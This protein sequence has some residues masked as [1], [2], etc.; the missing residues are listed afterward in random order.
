MGKRASSNVS[1]ATNSLQIVTF[2][3]WLSLPLSSP[4]YQ[5]LILKLSNFRYHFEAGNYGKILVEERTL[6]V[7]ADAEQQSRAHYEPKTTTNVQWT[8]G[9]RVHNWKQQ[10]AKVKIHLVGCP[11]SEK[12][13]QAITIFQNT[14]TSPLTVHWMARVSEIMSVER[15]RA[16]INSRQFAFKI[17]IRRLLCE[18]L[19][20]PL[21]LLLLRPSHCVI[22]NTIC[23]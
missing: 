10:L 7:S 16:V 8:N 1:I 4:L 23:I 5:F 17:P 21:P 9:D 3:I 22:S 6:A 12:N 20:L 13:S 2:I 19:L 15:E 11:T 18:T 14:E